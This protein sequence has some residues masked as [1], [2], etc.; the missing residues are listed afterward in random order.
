MTRMKDAVV[1]VTGGAN[2]IGRRYCEALAL[3]GAHVVVADSDADSAQRLAVALNRGAGEP[4]T[5]ACHV[6]VTFEQET[7]RLAQETVSAFGRVD[8]LINNAG[9]YP[10]APLAQ[11]DY[12]GWRRVVALNLDSV[13]LCTQAFLPMMVER[14]RGKVINVTTNLVWS[15]LA[16]MAPYIAAKAGVIGLTK[17]L[18]RELGE[19]GIS[20][21]ALAP[22][23]VIPN[24]R[25]TDEGNAMADEIVRNQCIRR[26]QQPED[27]VGAMLFLCSAASDFMSGQVVTVDGG[28]TMH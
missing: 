19:A 13:F 10:H 20:V 8:V 14:T 23:A 17:A 3:S 18:A 12:D 22:G 28:L 25:L 2:G 15:G 16:N 6:D 21:N 24:H 9:S 5:L 27:L 7:R 1:V 4:R 11:V 26:R